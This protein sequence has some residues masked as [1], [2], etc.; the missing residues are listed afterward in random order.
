MRRTFMQISTGLGVV[1]AASVGHAAT[2]AVVGD[3]PARPE[4][5][6]H[7]VAEGHE[8]IASS[9]LPA[10]LDGVEVVW[11]HGLSPLGRL[12]QARLVELLG[13]GRGVLLTG[14]VCCEAMNQSLELLVN[15]VVAGEHVVIGGMGTQSGAPHLVNPQAHGE[16]ASRPVPVTSWITGGAGG[17]KGVSGANVLAT[18]VDGVTTA[19]VWG[20]RH[21]ATGGRLVVMMDGDWYDHPDARPLVGNLATYLAE[22]EPS[23]DLPSGSVPGDTESTGELPGGGDDD[24]SEDGDGA[25]A[26]WA[27]ASGRWGH[28]G[29]A[30]DAEAEE[31]DETPATAGCSVAG[32]GGGGAGAVLALALAVLA[33]AGRRRRPA[34]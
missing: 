16:V 11:H 8:V 30:A 12:D 25:E 2:I 5:V 19:A 32:G 29:A 20:S 26:G 33:G 1:T 14:E 21:L 17:M 6:E 22:P 7:L 4:L 28:R 24:G 13:E 9:A 15:T 10:D 34:A 23:S 27:D 31:A 18:T 3:H